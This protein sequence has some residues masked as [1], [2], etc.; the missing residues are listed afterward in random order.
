VTV[1]LV[2]FGLGV[3]IAAAAIATACSPRESNN[4]LSPDDPGTP[5]PVATET[6]V[7][8]PTPVPAEGSPWPDASVALEHARVLSVEIGPRIAGSAGEDAAVA[9]IAA[10]FERHGYDVEIQEFSFEGN[11]FA[12]ATLELGE[13]AIEGLSMLGSGEGTT[14]GLIAFVG[15]GRA[16]DL[17]GMSLAG[18]IAVADR[19]EITFREKYER[20]SAAGAVGLVVVNDE[21]MPLVGGNLDTAASIPVIAV[22]LAERE[23]L[24]VAAEAGMEATVTA[25]GPVS[26]ST[27][28]L[29][30]SPGTARCLVLAGGHHDTVPASPGG[31][32]NASGVAHVLEISRAFAASGHEPG[33]CFA[34]FGAE[35]SGLF[36]SRE[37]ARQMTQTDQLPHYMVNFDVTGMGTQVEAIGSP[38]L[39]E[40]SI[41]LAAGEGVEVVPSLL[42][43]NTGSDHMSFAEQGVP[44]VF[45]TSGLYDE[46][47]TPLD[48]F[49]LLEHEAMEAIAIAGFLLVRDL[50]AEV[51]GD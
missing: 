38:E 25:D 5:T 11:R 13:T 37:M 26:T 42:P 27:N 44:V 48:T 17:A 45:F 31:N 30:K 3:I 20:V 50:Y 24:L 16:E 10:E 33:V 51:A 35:E 6:P 40:R 14:T 39:I 19:G 34:T 32:D 41:T 23:A 49:D 1:R 12:S 18:R 47:H 21:A 28:V 15:L 8:S 2:A 9:Y 36:G 29:A 43:P 46:I 7:P 22:S 4:S